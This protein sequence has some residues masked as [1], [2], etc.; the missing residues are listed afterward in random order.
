MDFFNEKSLPCLFP[1]PFHF[2]DCIH[3][4]GCG[5]SKLQHSES[6]SEPTQSRKTTGRFKN[7]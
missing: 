4:F 5:L 2:L 1:D 3:G 6:S 7:T